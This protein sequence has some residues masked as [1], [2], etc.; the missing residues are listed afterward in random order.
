MP[1]FLPTFP[2][3]E[4]VMSNEVSSWLTC[5][6]NVHL[7]KSIGLDHRIA[8][9]LTISKFPQVDI[10]N[11]ESDP[12]KTAHLTFNKVPVNMSPKWRTRPAVSRSAS[13]EI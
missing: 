12:K 7:R 6:N 8:Q 13:P 1:I 3:P 4:K 11:H 10:S 5:S 2:E 9:I